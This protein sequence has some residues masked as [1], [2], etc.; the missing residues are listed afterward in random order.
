M[1]YR[2][3]YCEE[4]LLKY[5]LGTLMLTV[6]GVTTHTIA[7]EYRHSTLKGNVTNIMTPTS[8]MR[9]TKPESGRVLLS[10]ISIHNSRCCCK[11]TPSTTG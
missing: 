10:P 1:Q 3:G 7:A 9:P 4:N 6:T 11:E 8:G 2:C 5:Y